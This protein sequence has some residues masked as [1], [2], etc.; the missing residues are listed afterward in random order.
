MSITW[1]ANR[2][3]ISSSLWRGVAIALAWQAA[4]GGIIWFVVRHAWVGR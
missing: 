1:G 4:M 2:P 3:R